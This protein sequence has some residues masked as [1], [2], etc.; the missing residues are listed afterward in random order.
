MK[1]FKFRYESLL[2]MRIEREDAVKHELAALFAEK[3]AREEAL[4][5]LNDRAQSY[6]LWIQEALDSGNAAVDRH[7]FFDGKQFYKQKKQVLAQEIQRVDERIE[8]TR[9]ALAEAMKERKVMEKLKEKA[10][11]AFIEAVNAAEVKVI[12]EIVNYNNTK[13]NGEDYGR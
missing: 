4:A 3:S 6:D 10:H 11:R 9:E 13:K 1:K 8:A 12:E 7:A 5:A 2:K